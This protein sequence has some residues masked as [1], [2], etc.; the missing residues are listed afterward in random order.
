MRTYTLESVE[1]KIANIDQFLARAGRKRVER[2]RLCEIRAN[3]LS[4]ENAEKAI[5]ALERKRK[6][7]ER[8]E[9]TV[10]IAKAS[11]L[12]AENGESTESENSE[13]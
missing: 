1:A 12:L 3:L 8:L 5:L 13:S 6:E 11:G 2:S 7:I 10:A 9:R 4:P